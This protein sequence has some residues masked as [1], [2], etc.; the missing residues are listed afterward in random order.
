MGSYE[1]MEDACSVARGVLSG[2]T[3]PNTG[4]AVIASI[5]LK[6]GY[7]ASLEMFVAIAHDQDG[8]EAF[9]ITAENCTHDIVDACRHLTAS[10]P[11]GR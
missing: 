11:W 7:P 8:H 9:G 6:L 2:Q 10:Q 3:N 5:A 4:C 1:S